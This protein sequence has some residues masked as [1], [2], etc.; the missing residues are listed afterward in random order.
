[1]KILLSILIIGIIPFTTFGQYL[2]PPRSLDSI[3]YGSKV[4]SLN[5]IYGNNKTI[6]ADHETAILATLS[7]FPELESTRI[8]FR[9]TKIR[10]TMNA[11]PTLMSMIFRKKENRKYVIRINN[12]QKQGKP[13]FSEAH[14][15]AQVGILGHE[16]SHIADYINQNFFGMSRRAIS[17][18]F[19]KSKAKYEGEID[20][21]TIE[22]GIGW[23]LYDW[24]HFVHHDSDASDKYKR[25]KSRIYLMPEDIMQ[26]IY[27]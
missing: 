15:N 7:F 3:H 24:K 27:E 13:L 16:F 20:A 23:Q 1:M 25:F 2:E 5:L 17:Y 14:F 9:E 18:L 6:P 11:R 12:T 8:E 10:T 22:K 26:L 21:Y 4:D 19:P